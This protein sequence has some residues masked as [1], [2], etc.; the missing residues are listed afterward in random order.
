MQ[1]MHKL[2]VSLS[3]DLCYTAFANTLISTPFQSHHVISSTIE[4]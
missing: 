4:Q 1:K 2:K 3:S